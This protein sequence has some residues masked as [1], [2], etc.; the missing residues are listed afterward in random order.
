TGVRVV[1]GER[2]ALH[3]V[4][5]IVGARIAVVADARRPAARAVLAR[6]GAV[7]AGAGV[8]VVARRTVRLLRVRRTAAGAVTHLGGVA[9]GG[10][11][12]T[13]HGHGREVR[14][15]RAGPVA[16]IG[17]VAHGVGLIAARCSRWRERVRWAVAGAVAELGDVA[18]AA[19]RAALRRRGGVVPPAGARA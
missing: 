3:G 5:R 12:A 13:G 1:V 19:R 2:A 11:R 10:G 17:L 14:P 9:L 8:A 18:I 4:A 16:G 7:R 6:I 15:A